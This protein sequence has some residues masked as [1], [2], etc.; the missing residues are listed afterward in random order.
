MQHATDPGTAARSPV[1]ADLYADVPYWSMPDRQADPNRI[2]LV[3][4][5]HGFEPPDP[6][7]ARV[8]ELG[9]GDGANLLAYAAAWPQSRCTGVDLNAAAI[10]RGSELASAAGLTNVDLRVGDLA[11]IDPRVGEFDYITLHGLVSWVPAH[12]RDA[13]LRIAAASLAPGGI[14]MCDYDALPGW[15]LWRPARELL[16]LGA[17]RAGDDARPA[18][19][20]AA[21]RAQLQAARDLNGGDGMYGQLLT[22]SVDRVCDTTSHLLFHD[23]M[24]PSLT[25]LWVDEM[26][27]LADAAGLGYIGE[28]LPSQWWEVNAGPAER[29]REFAG[30]DPVRGQKLADLVVGPQFKCTLFARADDGPSR[31]GLDPARVPEAVV[32]ADTAFD[33]LLVHDHPLIVGFV[34]HVRAAGPRGASLT[35]IAE[36]TGA[37]PDVVSHTAVTLA[38]SRALNLRL[39]HPPVAERPGVRPA[40]HALVR[41]Q[42][43]R[44]QVFTT[45]THDSVV[46]EDPCAIH[47]LQL[48][49]GTRD[50]AALAHELSVRM[51][52]RDDPALGAEISQIL[53]QFATHGLL[54]ET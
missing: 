50:L 33:D 21:A 47:L 42:T 48:L 38:T 9:C 13:A 40:V 34:D 8:L 14:V 27:A 15:A 3:A 10:S 12:V 37:D 44:T 36:A 16:L 52:R 23:D 45:R 28:L 2:G 19:R 51:Q 35:A 54:M 6:R 17:S 41:E 20:I 43:T 4:R 32:H 18:D 11:E 22:A 29:L 53:D 30:S 49:D 7:T 26:A 25:P 39:L 5:L 46:I 24:A 31:S 1:R